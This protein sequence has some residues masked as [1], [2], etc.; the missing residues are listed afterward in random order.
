MRQIRKKLIGIS[1]YTRRHQ[2][3]KKKND[4]GM[5]VAGKQKP[6]SRN[7]HRPNLRQFEH[8]S[9]SE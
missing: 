5:R 8:Q 1:C 3:I 4:D 7:S 9:N 6:A 2:S